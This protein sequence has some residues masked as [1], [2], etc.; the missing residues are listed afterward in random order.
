MIHITG[1]QSFG[2]SFFKIQLKYMADSAGMIK[3]SRLEGTLF[4]LSFLSLLFTLT[5]LLPFPH[6]FSCTLNLCFLMV[7]KLSST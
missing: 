4:P 6:L 1:L 5:P 3:R 2:I 7:T